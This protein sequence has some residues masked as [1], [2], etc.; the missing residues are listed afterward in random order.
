MQTFLPFSNIYKTAQCLDN[1]R[2]NKQ[3]V[4]A[5]QIIIDRVPTINHPA[6]L[7]WKDYKGFLRLYIDALC[8]EYKIRFKKDHSV[9]VSLG[10][11]T[12]AYPAKPFWYEN[13]V[14]HYSHVINLL[15]KDCEYYK[16]LGAFV[17]DEPEGYYWPVVKK[18][19][20]AWKDTQKW[21][22]WADKHNIKI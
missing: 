9:D 6:C 10:E 13:P 17:G 14:F 1:K 4:E 5:Y 15:R 21:M 3:I 11:I 7:M 2:L 20:K 8:R 19:G 18:G 16:C 12:E 22:V